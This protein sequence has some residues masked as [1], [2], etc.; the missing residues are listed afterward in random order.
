ME[1]H[2]EPSKPEDG[3]KPWKH[4]LI[5]FFMLFLAVTAGFFAENLRDRFEEDKKALQMAIGLYEELVQDSLQIHNAIIRQNLLKDE[6]SSLIKTLSDKDVENKITLLTYYEAGY[7]LE[8]DMVMPANANLKQLIESGRIR[9]FKNTEL[10]SDISRWDNVIS[11]QFTDRHETDQKRLIEE[12]KAVNRVFRPEITDTIRMYSF[13][14][15]LN[16]KELDAGN[17]E[18]F[19]NTKESLLTYNAVDISE[20]T[21]W[22]SERR[23]NAIVRSELFLPL[24]LTHIRKILKDLN[25]EF[26]MKR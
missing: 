21:G 12:I 11:V 14:D 2:H 20:V 8:T 18:R 25:E 9:Y 1:I 6:M 15:F 17:R 10:I 7:L 19:V 22:A 3:I 23:K 13:Y 16:N 5:E 26:D 24:Q 4:Y